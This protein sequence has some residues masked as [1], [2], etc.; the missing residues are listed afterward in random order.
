[1]NLAGPLLNNVLN[2]GN[3]NAPLSSL[4]SEE[5]VESDSLFM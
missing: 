5:D 2:P 3:I 4:V 1:M